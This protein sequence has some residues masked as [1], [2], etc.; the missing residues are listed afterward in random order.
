VTFFAVVAIIAVIILAWRPR[1][2]ALWQT[3]ERL[4][5]ARLPLGSDGIVR[6]AQPI[7]EG[8]HQRAALLLHG[9]G[10]TP[11]SV[12]YLA[13]RLADAGWTVSVPLLPGHGRTLDEFNRSRSHDWLAHAQKAFTELTARHAPVVVCGQSMGAALAIELAVTQPVD[14]LVL[15]APYIAM[16]RTGGVVAFAWPIVQGLYPVVRIRDERS[17]HD[18]QAGAQSLAYGYT[19]PRLLRELRDLVRRARNQL[20]AL[21]SATL[22]VHSREDN[23]VPPREVQRAVERIEYPDKSLHWV[24]GCGHVLTADYCKEAVAS[25]VVDWFERCTTR[26]SAATQ[27]R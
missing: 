27:A 7:F 20:R 14:A 3:A 18:A 8:G 16:P 6:G 25:L 2:R 26:E 24:N 22:I 23:R 12:V 13:R 17:I 4:I 21:R 15:L 5:A 9:F 19:T 10:D 1:R 11:Q